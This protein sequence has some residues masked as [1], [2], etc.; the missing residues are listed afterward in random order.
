VRHAQLTHL[1]AAGFE[2]LR[3]VSSGDS[4]ILCVIFRWLE[5]LLLSPTNPPKSEPIVGRD[6]DSPRPRVASS[7]RKQVAEG[8]K[9]ILR[10]ML[11]W[12]PTPLSSCYA[13][14][15]SFYCSPASAFRGRSSTRVSCCSSSSLSNVVYIITVSDCP[16]LSV[17]S[18][19]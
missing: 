10:D 8:Y 19:C 13:I 17:T 3:L 9:R 1:L 5:C 16:C 11:R 14:V 18:S 12:A 2:E 15:R 4:L 7:P 6:G